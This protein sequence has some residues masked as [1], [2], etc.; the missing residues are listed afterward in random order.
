MK[1]IL[2]IALTLIAGSLLEVSAQI[3]EGK[4]CRRIEKEVDRFSDKIYYRTPILDPIVMTLIVENGSTEYLISIEAPGSIPDTGN[5]AYILFKDGS[6][7]KK[8][9]D[10]DVRVSYIAEFK[11]KASFYLTDQDI[12][13]LSTKEI[14]AI[15]VYIYEAEIRNAKKYMAYIN[16]L[17]R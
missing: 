8:D 13:M 5:G 2:V 1:K 6:I 14:E 11:H 4:Y 17:T 9:V 3:R 7:I 10:T 15:K 16:C 12:K